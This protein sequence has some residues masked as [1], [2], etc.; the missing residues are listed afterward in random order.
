MLAMLAP[1]RFWACSLCPFHYEIEP[2]RRVLRKVVLAG[3]AHLVSVRGSSPPPLLHRAQ[4][5]ALADAL[6]RPVPGRRVLWEA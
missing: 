5:A 2:P 4:L 6:G 3:L 1:W